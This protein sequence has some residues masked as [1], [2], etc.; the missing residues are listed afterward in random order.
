MDKTQRA[1]IKRLSTIPRFLDIH[2]KALAPLARGTTRAELDELL[3]EA[4]RLG[5]AQITAAERSLSQ[6]ALLGEL[7]LNLHRIHLRP[8]IAVAGARIGRKRAAAHLK[9][10][11]QTASD[12]ELVD[13]AMSVAAVLRKRKSVFVAECFDAD[14]LDQL[15]A[16]AEALTAAGKEADRCREASRTATN[17]IASLVKRGRELLQF[18]DALVTSKARRDKRLLADWRRTAGIRCNKPLPRTAPVPTASSDEQPL[19]GE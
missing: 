17:D 16:A 8:I 4:Q 5:V 6:T 19:G 2:A 10:P 15:V 18:F 12:R 13:T 1:H 9:L 14:F 7:R 11:R 3:T